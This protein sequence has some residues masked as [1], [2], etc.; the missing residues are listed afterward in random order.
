MSRRPHL[1]FAGCCLIGVFL[2]CNPE[3]Q[4]QKEDQDIQQLKAKWIFD[5]EKDHPCPVLPPIN[6]D[7]LCRA[8][9]GRSIQQDS[10]VQ[11]GRSIQQDSSAQPGHSVQPGP[12]PP[13]QPPPCSPERILVPY[14][15]TRMVQ[16][17]NDSL[18]AKEQELMTARTGTKVETQD[19][20]AAVKAAQASADK[21]IWWLVASVLF[22]IVLIALIIWF[23]I[24]NP[25]KLLK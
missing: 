6:L 24:S 1:W 14:L 7:S 2:A 20:S 17:L 3:R 15:D 21:W 10:S 18:K 5:W 11:P 9:P 23:F 12:V 4:I 8:Q 16:L 19:C 22:N 13:V 25:L